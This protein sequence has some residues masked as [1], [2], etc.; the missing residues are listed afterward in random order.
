MLP[1]ND[2]ALLNVHGVTGSIINVPGHGDVDITYYLIHHYAPTYW[3]STI[4]KRAQEML[5]DWS[6]S[7]P[8]NVDAN[9]RGTEIARAERERTD[10][11]RRNEEKK[12][13]QERANDFMMDG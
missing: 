5:W 9:R 7:G 13:S 4:G 8:A 2:V 1:D 6:H 3:W 12:R 11:Q 10:L